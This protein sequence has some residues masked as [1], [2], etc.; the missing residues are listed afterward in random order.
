[1][2]LFGVQLLQLLTVLAG[3]LAI[4]GMLAALLMRAADW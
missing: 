2:D 4:A 3:A 1:V